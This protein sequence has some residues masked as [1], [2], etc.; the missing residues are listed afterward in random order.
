MKRHGFTLIELIV[1]IAIIGV[2][3]AILVP[4]MIGYVSRSKV[5]NS[6]ASAKS[7]YNAMNIAMVEMEAYDLPPQQLVGDKQYTGAQ[8]YAMRDFVIPSTPTNNYTTL[9][10]ILFAKVCSYFPDINKVKDFAVRLEDGGCAGVAVMS[11]KY[12]GTYPQAI[13]VE[14]F[15]AHR[16][17]WDCSFALSFALTP[18]SI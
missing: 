4:A 14:I 6:N 17:D 13:T 11:G 3:A 7:I 8:V 5:T 16:G 12:P 18:M 2:L 10:S 1:V 9:E 15:K